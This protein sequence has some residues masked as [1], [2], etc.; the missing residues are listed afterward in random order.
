MTITEPTHA[1]LTAPHPQVLRSR[2]VAPVPQPASEAGAA[3]DVSMRR[4]EAIARAGDMIPA[5]YR[6]K[7]GAIMLAEDWANRR[8]VDL[9]TAMQTVSFVGGKPIVDSGMQR[10]L[11][12]R[13]GYDVR[14]TEASTTSATVSVYRSGELLGTE[15]Y[16]LAEAEQAGLTKKAGSLWPKYPKN[17]LVARASTNA[18]RFYAP[19]VMIGLSIAD[20][21]GEEDPLQALAPV[22]DAPAEAAPVAVVEP[23]VVDAEVVD[24]PA[25]GVEVPSVG[26]DASTPAGDTAPTAPADV[27]DADPLDELKARAKAG[28]LTQG[29]AI[30]LS[31]DLAQA[32]QMKAPATLADVVANP[33]LAALLN[34]V[35]AQRIAEG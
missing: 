8:D 35:I 30:K 10:A 17:M 24:E 5:A 25:A 13:A 11:A 20:E 21:I 23:D 19:S 32:H 29:D 27:G 31:I 16:T 2:S 33:E 7:P 14:V 3:L 18:L 34:G 1:A 28:G 4:A 9:L 15:T 12:E 22:A 26:A 6:G